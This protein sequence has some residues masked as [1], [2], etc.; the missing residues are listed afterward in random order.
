[1]AKAISTTQGGKAPGPDGV[2]AD[3]YKADSSLWADILTHVFN[4]AC[5]VGLPSS[6]MKAVIVPIFKKGSRDDPACYRPISLLDS[7]AKIMGTVILDRLS[8][9]LDQAH[10]IRLTVW[11]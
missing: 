9:W 6:W 5:V 1:M 7:A 4:A 8:E 2:P 10:H 11:I 3:L